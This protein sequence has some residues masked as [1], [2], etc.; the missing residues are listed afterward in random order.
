[1]TEPTEQSHPDW[2]REPNRRERA[3]ATWL[4]IGFG[5]FFALLFFVLAGWWF[6]WV[7]LSLGVISVVSGIQH[8]ARARQ[9]DEEQR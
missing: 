4:F 8:A 6:R 9:K 7:I 1:M 2:F 5:V 3:I